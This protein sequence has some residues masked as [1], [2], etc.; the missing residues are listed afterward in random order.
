MS[1]QIN[2]A[3]AAPLRI[4]LLMAEEGAVYREYALA[5]ANE[6][7]QN[8]AAIF[9]R[10]TA[11]SL[12]DTDLII[13]LGIKSTAFALEGQAPVISVLV[14]KAAFTKLSESSAAQRDPYP[15][16]AIFLDHPASR[17]LD[18]VAAVLPRATTVGVL[19]S[20]LP[21]EIDSFR[22]AAAENKLKL[23]EQRLHSPE[24]LHR[25]LLT[26][27]Q[28]SDV[29][30]ALPDAQVYNASTIRNVLLETYRSKTPM[31]GISASYV[32]AGA[33]CAVYSSPQQ[34]ARQTLQMVRQFTA[35]GKMPT[36]QYPREFDV[37]VN[38]QVA[39]SLGIQMKTTETLIRQMKASAKEEGGGK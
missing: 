17:Q 2:P 29:L 18:L 22:R 34:I 33:L 35:S 8:N 37:L 20:R 32:K 13:A 9:I 26:L 24:S 14:S 28:Q 25:D 11:T 31:F 6:V 30:L 38:Q 12:E 3:Q 7:E 36:V 15:F 10:Q 4:T 21:P 19:Y 5:F 23:V 16:S 1:W 39:N 27:V